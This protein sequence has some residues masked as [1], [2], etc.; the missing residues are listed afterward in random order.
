MLLLIKLL[1]AVSCLEAGAAPAFDGWQAMRVIEQEGAPRVLRFA[2]LD[3]DQCDE[4]IV[5]NG[6]HSRLD[7]YGWVPADERRAAAA[8]DGERP[9]DL[10]M[11]EDFERDELALEYLPRDVAVTDLDGDGAPELVVLVS[12]PNKVLVYEQ[13]SEKNQWQKRHDFDLLAGQIG[14]RHKPMLLRRRRDGA[15]EVFVGFD[16]GVQVLRL[17]PD[18][19]ADWLKPRERRDRLDWWFADVDGDGDQD[20]IEQSRAASESIRWYV[21]TA[22]DQLMPAQVLHDRAIAGMSVLQH[23]E[24][25][26]PGH[27]LLLD[28]AT[29]GL[30]R[31]YHLDRGEPSPLGQRRVLAVA[32][33]AQALWCGVQLGDV[34]ALVLVDNEQ[35]RLLAYG[36]GAE[37]WQTEKSFPAIS[38]VKAIAAPQAQPGTL[39][40]WAKDASDLYISRWENGRL[41]YPKVWP[42]SPQVED[43][44][45]LAMASVHST[46]WWV[47]KV[48]DELD[49]YVWPDTEDEPVRTRYSTPDEKKKIGRDANKVMWLGGTRLL[50]KA[51]HARTARLAVVSD[52]QTIMSE[53]SHLS[54]ADMSQY[55][56]MPV[57]C[58]IVPA[59]LND[60]VLQWLD[61]DLFP[62]DQVMLGQGQKLSAYA[63]LDE[64][65]G[66]A[67]QQDGQFVHLM[68]AD[69]AGIAQVTRSIKMEGGLSLVADS[70]LGL[71][72]VDHNRLVHLSEGRPAQIKLIESL[73]SRVGRA[74]GVKEATIHR[75]D[76]AD[77]L[78][79]GRQEVLLFDDRRHHM[80]VLAQCGG[81][82]K[83]Q[84]A[85]PVFED[86][87]YPYSNDNAPL[88]REPRAVAAL[89]LDGDR[90][91]DLAMLCHD[92]LILYL[93]SEAP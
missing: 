18:S 44:K 86:R 22:G 50:V 55:M 46:A 33:G 3:G 36:L 14:P 65:R 79:D 60:G 43:R 67:L 24:P 89:D 59:R 54:K 72:V 69:E 47:Q 17:E 21:C 35:P 42:Q 9:N 20:L 10:P 58:S 88:V 85:W 26:G 5:I 62:Q 8:P 61:E 15:P 27:F 57:G 28:G 19:R 68:E 76:T 39:L 64:R 56:L 92:R 32:D 80:T 93:A 13:A 82:L 34:P 7:L 25:D 48:G 4:V 31:R 84:I 78:G 38:D 66:W 77:V 81:K 74:S 23:A 49:L 40:L 71:M 30:L 16:D 37:G 73:D 87:R 45:I 12:P 70:V 63:V 51:Q 83:P 1:A 2:D 6:R 41:T 75:L 53:P 11:A 29:A 90:Q 52:G 91:Q